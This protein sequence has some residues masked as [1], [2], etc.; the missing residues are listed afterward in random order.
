MRFGGAKE[1]IPIG[2]GQ[3]R[4]QRLGAAGISTAHN[5]D[6]L[7]NRRLD[8]TLRN[9]RSKSDVALSRS[10]RGHDDDRR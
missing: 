2:A 8:D 3:G 6:Q 5:G 7:T 4:R 9:A 1:L 10:S